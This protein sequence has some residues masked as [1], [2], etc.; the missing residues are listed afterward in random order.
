[1]SAAADGEATP[2]ADR[3]GQALAV[4]LEGVWPGAP[5]DKRFRLVVAGTSKIATNE[6]FPYVSNG[7]LSVAMVRWLA[8][9]DATPN[10]APQT[11]NQP[12]IVLT[13]RQMRDTFIALEVSFA[14]DHRFLRCADVVETALTKAAARRDA[15]R[16][17]TPLAAAV[18]V[19]LLGA[20]LATGRWPELR[21]KA[22]FSSKG[23][24]TIVP[25]EIYR[26]EVRSSS[27]RV[28]LHR[29]A[30]GWSI[31]GKQGAVPAEL[32][33]HLGTALRLMNV[34]EPTR[35]IPA[36]ELSV[37]SF[38]EFGLDPPAM[39]AVLET[40]TGVAASVNFGAL[41]PAGTSHYARL[42]GAPAIYL[43][44][45]H[46]E[47]EWRVVF[48]MARRLPGPSEPAIASRGTGLLLPVSMAQVWA[49]EI[50]FAGKLS[51]F[52]RD[53]AGNWF[54]HTGQHAH[55]A[56]NSAHVA[57]PRKPA[58][59]TQRSVHSIPLR[60]KPMSGLPI[61]RGW[62]NTASPYRR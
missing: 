57:D 7:E 13:S 25:S 56:D 47:G 49:I 50:V 40:R 19:V 53:A 41:N 44:G 29:K 10:V 38:A 52:E 26:V 8:E 55:T 14:P 3:G 1:M 54:K 33:S 15:A 16:W 61:R 28:T 36:N 20:L 30:G 45:R 24:V 35:E 59:S 27:D 9:D 23:L 17:R 51:R 42:A 4:A 2:K 11:Y 37:G 22:A 32:A 46:V 12:E 60:S 5:P 18:L 39:V 31:D 43:M 21:S 62:P 34:S 6:Y 58:S 48:D